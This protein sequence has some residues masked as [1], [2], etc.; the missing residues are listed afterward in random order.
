M[1]QKFWFEF[2]TYEY[3]N[4]EYRLIDVGSYDAVFGVDGFYG[5]L[6]T[7]VRFNSDLIKSLKKDIIQHEHERIAKA[8]GKPLK[9]IKQEKVI[10]VFLG[11][12]IPC[13]IIN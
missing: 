8:T 2:K 11:S 9:Q 5:T 1:H 3:V 10:S 12:P 6:V 4:G 7:P 13:E